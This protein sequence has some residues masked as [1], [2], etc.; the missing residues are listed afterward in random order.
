MSIVMS[1][2]E[3]TYGERPDP[4]GVALAMPDGRTVPAER[5]VGVS[6][7]K[8]ILDD[9]GKFAEAYPPERG[10]IPRQRISSWAN[11]WRSTGFP[12][13]LPI[14]P[15]GC[16]DR[17]LLWDADEVRAWPG[18]PGRWRHSLDLNADVPRPSGADGVRG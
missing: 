16:L 4:R 9:S 15:D 5:I 13:A 10:G 6:E 1:T 11:R 7:V 17:G 2:Y 18:L 3:A 8:Q 12:K 14:G